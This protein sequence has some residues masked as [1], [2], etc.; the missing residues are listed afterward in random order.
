MTVFFYIRLPEAYVY[1]FHV[2]VEKFKNTM[3]LNGYSET[4]FDRIVRFYE[5]NI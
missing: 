4:I 2:D 3:I 1:R 5:Q